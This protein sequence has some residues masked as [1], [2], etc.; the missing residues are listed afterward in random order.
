[1]KE[2]VEILE[3]F[4]KEIASE[5]TLKNGKMKSRDFVRNSKLGFTK[6]IKIILSRTGKTTTNEINN[7]Y[8]EIDK[9]EY[10]IS[11]QALFQAQRKLN[12][13]VF[14][15]LNHTLIKNFY[16]QNHMKKYKDHLILAIDGTVLEM[17][18][19][20]KT[21]DKFGT[22]TGPSKPTKTSPRSSG[23]YDCLN[24]I[25]AEFITKNWKESEIPMAYEQVNIINNMNLNEK[26]IFIADRYYGATDLFIYLE[27]IGYNYCFRGKKNFYKHYLDLNEKD[28][29]YE[30]PLDERWIKRLKIEEAKQ[31]AL[32]THKLTIRVIRFYK[33]EISL[34]EKITND[35][36]II[37]FTN[38]PPDKF[39]R[40]EIIKLYGIR[41]NIE[42]GYGILKTKMEFE[43]VTSEKP[44]IIL[45]EI[46]SQIIIYNL[47]ILLKNIADK[48]VN[49]TSKYNYQININN[50]IILF[51]KWL[52]KLLNDIKLI[53][54]IILKIIGRIVKNKEPIRKNRFFPRWKVYISK[55]STLKFRVDGKRNPKTHK[56]NKGYLR[57]SG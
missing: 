29:I 56:T 49:G 51:R 20:E 39:S 17:P 2:Y 38:L 14:R 24:N 23:I 47:M 15:K 8:S 3:N 42:T 11:K 28:K 10:T 22:I 31:I 25:Y 40:E 9:L 55:P 30:I 13:E 44:N 35:E 48:Q 50:L 45:Q 43:R 21:I 52:P 6:L 5:N 19:N 41:W 57:V 37:L 33:S 18:I 34:K 46:Y 7:Y 26:I 16:S 27:S 32:K 4:V 53:K 12:P 1:M 54:K 36:E